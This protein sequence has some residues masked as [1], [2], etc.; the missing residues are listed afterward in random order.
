MWLFRILILKC[1]DTEVKGYIWYL[2]SGWVYFAIWIAGIFLVYQKIELTGYWTYTKWIAYSLLA[3]DLTTLFRSFGK[4]KKEKEELMNA[5]DE[6]P[7]W[8]E[9]M[10]KR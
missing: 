10:R 4:Y 1:K 5:Q 3:P 8:L 9:E 7:E 2:V 6:V